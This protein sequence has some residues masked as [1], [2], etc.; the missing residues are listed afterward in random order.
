M[1]A[2][3]VASYMNCIWI[4]LRSKRL[5]EI[6]FVVDTKSSAIKVKEDGPDHIYSIPLLLE[7]T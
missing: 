2:A 7:E 5:A 1:V 3:I 4:Q 6:L